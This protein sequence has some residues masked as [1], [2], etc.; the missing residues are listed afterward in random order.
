MRRFGIGLVIFLLCLFLVFLLA[1]SSV[2]RSS[3]YEEDYYTS[4]VSRIDS[5]SKSISVNNDSLQAGFARVSIT[6]VLSSTDNDWEKGIFTYVPLAGYGDRKGKPAT[7]IHDSLFVRSVALR[8]GG[9]LVIL[10]TADL[11][12][13][14]PQITDTISL[15]L[16]KKG[17]SREQLFFSAT[18]CHSSLG[19]WGPGYIG[20]QFAGG[21]NRGIQK[22]IVIKTCESV[23][24]AIDDLKPSK[25]GT[26]CFNAAGYTRNRFIGESGTKNNDFCFISIEQNG[27]ER[28]IIG[29]FSAHATALG[30]D[31]MEISA[32]YP[33]CWS[34]RMESTSANIALFFA[35]ATGSQSLVAEGDGFAK[36]E[37][38]GE[39]LADSLNVI[40]KGIHATDRPEFS[41]V[42]L[43]IQLPEYHIRLT[44]KIN[45]STYL[46]KK[47][48]PLPE[49]VYLQA[50]RIGNMVWIT[51]PADFSGEFALQLKNALLA[52]G[53]TCNVSSFNGSYVGY[54]VPGKYFY[55]QEYESG[56]MGWFGP[57]MGDY[58]MDIIRQIT[59]IVTGNYNI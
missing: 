42:S 11:L 21:S 26:G 59:R 14:P 47:L 56:L 54:I 53:F 36:A 32:D 20:R 31:N 1:T 25:I 17:I 45:L 7:G 37:W 29:S 58:T 19:G 22:W 35:G 46:S 40:L 41:Y 5:I 2:K 38:L 48:M 52:E 57:N 12:I 8:S 23:L 50:L 3:Y 28:A 43:K 10:V 51:T 6:P 16:S 55:L 15:I 27:A 34:R 30:D 44:K 18:H 39:T 49:N 24:S 9:K 33:G 4:T 13:M